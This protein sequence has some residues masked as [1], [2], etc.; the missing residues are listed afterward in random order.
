MVVEVDDCERRFGRDSAE[1]RGVEGGEGGLAARVGRAGRGEG[2]DDLRKSFLI[3]KEE[4][5]KTKREKN[6]DP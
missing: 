6:S 3:S 5:E 4:V 1:F 2:L